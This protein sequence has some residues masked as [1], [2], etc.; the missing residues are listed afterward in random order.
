MNPLKFLL[1]NQLKLQKPTLKTGGFTLIELLVALVLA[2][3]VITPLLGF[4]IN[5]LESDRKEQ[6]KSNAEQEIQTALD[7]IKQDLEQAVYIYDADGL[8]K[9]GTQDRSTSG[10]KNQI[11]P[12]ASAGVSGCDT[13]NC[14]PVLVF[15]KRQLKPM[16]IPNGG[17]NDCGTIK[18]EKDRRLKC[19]DAYVYSL[20]GYYLITGN[21]PGQ[22]WSNVARIARFEISD[23]IRNPDSKTNK[24]EPFIKYDSKKQEPEPGFKIFDLRGLGTLKQ[25]MNLWKKDTGNYKFDFGNTVLVDYVD[26]PNPSLSDPPPGGIKCDP[27]NINPVVTPKIPREQRVPSNTKINNFYACVSSPSV[28]SNS[29]YARIYIRGNALARMQKTN[30][31]P[32]YNANNSAF[33]PTVTVQVQGNSFLFTRQ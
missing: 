2:F 32:S 10:I 3:L 9:M 14:T 13:T 31:P 22:P 7:Y 15:W 30:P 20:I 5:V 8:D 4:A 23:G 33:F 6:V 17:I 24:A 11:P 12:V 26:L 16:V 18:Q 19:D 1:T 27:T 21:S 29:N 28:N 25:K